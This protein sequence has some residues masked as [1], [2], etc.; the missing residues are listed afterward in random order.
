M[1]PPPHSRRPVT[2]AHDHE[3]AYDERIAEFKRSSSFVRSLPSC[4]FIGLCSEQG[5]NEVL[6]SRVHGRGTGGY[7]HA[8]F[9]G[10]V[11]EAT[12]ADTK[13]GTFV[14]VK[15]R[16]PEA[17]IYK[18]RIGRL[19]LGIDPVRL[20]ESERVSHLPAQRK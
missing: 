19:R 2:H 8:P 12:I 16:P 13:N 6:K 10:C 1:R 20:V 15:I 5:L 7:V 18:N 3:A 4:R 11:E 14:A 9:A 17:I